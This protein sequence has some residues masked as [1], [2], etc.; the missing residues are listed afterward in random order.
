MAEK[1]E[2]SVVANDLASGALNLI[3]DKLASIGGTTA[4]VGTA[5]VT[6][7][8]A[9][10]GALAASTDAAYA[11]DQQVKELMLRTGGTAEE[12]SRLIQ[13]VDDAGIE[14]GTLTT[15]MKFAVKNGIEPN[16][17]SLIKLSDEYLALAPGVERGKFLLDKFGKSGMDMARIMDLGGDAIAKMNSG[18]EDNL[19]LTDEAIKQSEEYRLNVDALN[20]SMLGLK[21]SIGNQVI[22]VLNDFISKTGE[23]A[24]S[25]N[26]VAEAT[27]RTDLRSKI[28]IGNIIQLQKEQAAANEATKAGNY[29]MADS[30]DAA[31]RASSSIKI[32]TEDLV[33]QEAAQKA[34]TE[35]NKGFL[36][37]LSSIASSEASYS[38][39]ANALAQDRVKIEQERAAAIA[40]GW[41]ESSD[42]VKQYDAALAENDVKVAANA[43]AHDLANK[44]I[45]LG[46]LER[47]LM[48]DG[49]LDDRELQFLLDKGLAWG[50]YSQ[51]VVTETQKAIAEANK[52]SDVING[53]PTSKTF[54]LTV[55]QQGTINAF[56]Q[57]LNMGPRGATGRASGGSVNA[58]QMYTVGEA[59]PELFIPNTNGTII[60]NGGGGSNIVFNLSLNSAVSVLDE[61]RAKT[62]LYPFVEA[63]ASRLKSEGKIS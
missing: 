16:V 61:T 43:A 28:Y 33:A 48:Q 14:Y 27:G 56:Y 59:G 52:L 47:K 11:Y 4:L 31:D 29:L 12:T 30:G 25:Q 32:L 7:G 3:K 49:V 18:V 51:T 10:V 2:I 23:F 55:Q 45:I 57:S 20:D 39:T 44:Q 1:V 50:V 15:A 53:I 19:V 58:N 46:L 9:V 35:A 40:A 34:M 54:T 8:V 13:V 36:S 38:S 37:T 42:K 63:I 22:P 62:V 21:V 24:A 41:W 60:P 6:M 5:A 26:E 17:Q